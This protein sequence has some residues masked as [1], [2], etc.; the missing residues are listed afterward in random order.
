MARY[1]YQFDEEDPNA[2]YQEPPPEEQ[3]PQPDQ[4]APDFSQPSKAG[5]PASD[6]S[7]G[8]PQT[9][10]PGSY[11]EYVRRG[12]GFMPP[13]GAVGGIVQ[14]EPTPQTM[15]EQMAPSAGAANPAPATP[16]TQPAVGGSFDRTKFRDAWMSQGAG[17]GGDVGRFIREHPEFASGVQS[18]GGS[19]DRYRLPTGEVLD[20]VID[21]GAGGRNAA[22]WTDTG[23]NQRGGGGGEPAPTPVGPVGG[24]GLPTGLGGG[25]GNGPGGTGLDPTIRQGIMDLLRNSQSPVNADALNASPEAQAFRRVAEREM[26]RQRAQSAESA[27]ARGV[28]ATGVAGEQS[29]ALQSAIG[30]GQEGLAERMQGMQSQLVSRELQNKREGI[31]QALQLGAGVMGRDQEV[32]LR[33]QL[34]ALDAQLRRE[35]YRSQEGMLGSELG[36]RERLQGNQLGFDYG[37]LNTRNDLEQQRINNEME[38]YYGGTGR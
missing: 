34:A 12:G 17:Y 31:V 27:A 21:A 15:G 10:A 2:G 14:G 16:Q 38:R 23:G 8:N 4:Q 36:S 6:W 35:G 18:V 32:Q 22:G 26:M 7:A 25:G 1:P 11:D 30:Q 24:G 13:G 37:A 9:P 33:Q 3:Q 29:G 20:L 5:A 19:T 28:G